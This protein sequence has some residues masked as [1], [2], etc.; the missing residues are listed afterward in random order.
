MWCRDQDTG[1]RQFRYMR[2]WCGLNASS[3]GSRV[4]EP[5]CPRCVCGHSTYRPVC[6]EQMA[7]RCCQ[8][9]GDPAAHDP[10]L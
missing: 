8:E 6:P 4:L 10:R 5:G 9:G 1:P 7:P 2:F 3:V